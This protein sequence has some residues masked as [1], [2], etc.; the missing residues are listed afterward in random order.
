M[1]PLFPVGST[2]EKIWPKCHIK[3]PKIT[4]HHQKDVTLYQ[5]ILTEPIWVARLL[6]KEDIEGKGEEEEEKEEVEEEEEK[7]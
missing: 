4:S 1:K 7:E 6:I 5:R 3:S 2:S